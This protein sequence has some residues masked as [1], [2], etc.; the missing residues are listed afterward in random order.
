MGTHEEAGHVFGDY[1]TGLDRGGT[2]T[3]VFPFPSRANRVRPEEVIFGHGVRRSLGNWHR[4]AHSLSERHKVTPRPP[5]GR[6]LQIEAD[7]KT[8]LR[9]NQ[10]APIVRL[11]C[12]GDSTVA[13]A[14]HELCSSVDNPEPHARHAQRS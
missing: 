3:R 14:D 12:P 7:L 2:P 4:S 11:A 5:G 13:V 9:P 6:T 10:L 8:G 1:P